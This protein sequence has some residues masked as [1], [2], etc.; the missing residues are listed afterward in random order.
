[1]TINHPPN[2]SP[3]ES[4]LPTAPAEITRID[5]T[6]GPVSRPRVSAMGSHQPAAGA[7]LRGAGTMNRPNAALSNPHA[8]A[9]L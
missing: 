5:A 3:I 9:E 2:R 1:M 4:C 7:A 8:R 6:T